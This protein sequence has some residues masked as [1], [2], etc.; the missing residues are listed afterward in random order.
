LIAAGSC[1]KILRVWS[2]HNAEPVAVLSRHSGMITAVN[3]CP[4]SLDNDQYFLA[5]TSGDGSVSFW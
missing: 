1:D 4:M 2:L 3:F 5:S